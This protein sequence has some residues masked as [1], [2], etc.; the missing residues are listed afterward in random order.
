MLAFLPTLAFAGIWEP[1]PGRVYVLDVA[2][3]EVYE[4]SDGDRR[5]A[6]SLVANLE[7]RGGVV[8]SQA[9]FARASGRLTVG[10]DEVE[11]DVFQRVDQPDVFLVIHR[12]YWFHVDFGKREIRL[13]GE[14]ATPSLHYPPSRDFVVALNGFSGLPVQDPGKSPVFE[15]SRVSWY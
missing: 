12:R 10:G 7:K 5:W 3:V 4:T 11:A 2:G 13:V 1:D 6:A 15:D 8:R 9:V 14:A